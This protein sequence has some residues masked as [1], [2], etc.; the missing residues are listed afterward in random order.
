M[1]FAI[2][3]LV[4]VLAIVGIIAMFKI[5]VRAFKVSKAWGMLFLIGPTVAALAAIVVG[6]LLAG[7]GLYASQGYFI[8]KH[9]EDVKGP[10]LAFVGSWA[11]IVVA[12]G[13]TV[14]FIPKKTLARFRSP[15]AA[16]VIAAAGPSDAYLYVEGRRIWYKVTG[17]GTGTPVI[18]LHGGPGYPSF[19]LKPL[20]ALGNDRPVVRYDQLGS[21]RSERAVDTTLFTIAHLVGE[22]DSLR[23]SLGYETVHIVGHSRGAI[24]AF[25]YYRAF[26]QHVAS[27]TLSSAA[28]SAPAWASNAK[29]LV[30]TLSD[31]AQAAILAR[32]TLHDYDAPDYLDA[33]NEFSGRYV[34]LRPVQAD[35]DSTT[36]MMSGAIYTY[37]WGPSEFT[38]TGTLRD[39]DATSQLRTIKVRTLYTVGEFDEADPATIKRF[40]A[41][42]PGAQIE[43]IP[44]AAHIT[45]W[46]NPDA[47]LAVVRA[48]L[49]SVDSSSLKRK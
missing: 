14:G 17:T 33:V 39:Y 31:S 28:L 29:R 44:G 47:T 10:F 21:G 9:W 41:R 13:I 45:T 48:F 16:P 23:A 27:L 30:A 12:L 15:E 38:I 1:F 40:A 25:E 11:V 35:L 4:L 7:V 18:L 19:S 36:A 49:R 6:P 5:V 3:L 2:E 37:M 22:L 34:T 8:K 42:T 32:E 46:D 43:V 20:E 24:L 26:P